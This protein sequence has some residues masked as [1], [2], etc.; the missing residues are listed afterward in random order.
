MGYGKRIHRPGLV[1]HVINRGNNRQA[2]FLEDEDYEKYLGLLYRYKVKY[3]FKLF[4]FCLMTNHVHLLIKVGEKFTISKIMQSL[5]NAH[6][7]HYHFKYQTGGHIWQ[8][9]F[10]SPIISDDEYMLRVMQYIEQNP[11]RAKMV[12]GVGDYRWS[13]YRL[14]VSGKEPKMIDRNGNTVFLQL[15]DGINDAR[16]KYHQLMQEDL[17]EKQLEGIR[18]SETTTGYMSE[19]FKEQMEEM[20][21]KKRKRGRPR[22]IKTQV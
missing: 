6:T 17:K 4:A 12:S 7:R 8:G 15:G 11:V 20:L 9:R 2:I 1:Y 19:R 3:G 21:P 13:S 16:K 5:T 10:K 14:N 18:K 22:R